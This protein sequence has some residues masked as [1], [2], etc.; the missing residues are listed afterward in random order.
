MM[1][2]CFQML[3][4]ETANTEKFTGRIIKKK[5]NVSELSEINTESHKNNNVFLY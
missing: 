1:P 5:K 4:Q 2:N 3:K